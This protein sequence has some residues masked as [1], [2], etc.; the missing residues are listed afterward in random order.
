MVYIHTVAVNNPKFIELQYLTL[1]KFV[2]NDFEF[3]VYNDAKSWND[4]TNFNNF[5]KQYTKNEITKTCE[6]LNIKCID[7]PNLH[8]STYRFDP[9]DRNANS[10]NFIYKDLLTINKPSLFIDS[11]MFIINDIDILE[12]YKNYNLAVVPQYRQMPICINNISSVLDV[13]YF[14]TGLYYFDMPNMKNKNLMD[15]NKIP[16][17]DT[18]GATYDYL[19]NNDDT[20]NPIYDI[21]FL[22]SNCWNASNLPSFINRKVLNF[23]ENDPKNYS[24]KYYAELYDDTYFHLRAATNWDYAG[25]NVN[26][27]RN[28]ILYDTIIDIL[29]S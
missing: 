24:E 20:E 6:S 25:F 11:D 15:F 3:V 23:L 21:K 4:L 8:H 19:M 17:T 26:N 13:K 29:K 7:I 1:K 12:K 22:K 10:I 16:H 9:S 2:K 14:W 18:G 27:K 28:T 5:D